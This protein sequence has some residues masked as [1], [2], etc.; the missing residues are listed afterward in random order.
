MPHNH[1]RLVRSQTATISRMN[2]VLPMSRAPLKLRTAV[3]GPQQN[4]GSVLR[5]QVTACAPRLMTARQVLAACKVK[6]L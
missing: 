5:W 6:L 1:L 3:L 2:S 4:L